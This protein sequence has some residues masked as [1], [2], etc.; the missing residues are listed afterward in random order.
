MPIATI[1]D[2]SV[3]AVYQA[4]TEELLEKALFVEGKTWFLDSELFMDS[5]I[6]EPFTCESMP[7]DVLMLMQ[8]ADDRIREALYFMDLETNK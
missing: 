1:E 5:H 3:I 4:R 8:L 7:K 6:I 2:L